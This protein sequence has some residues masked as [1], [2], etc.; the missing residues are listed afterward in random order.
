MALKVTHLQRIVKKV[1][2]TFENMNN[3]AASY[4][5]IISILIDPKV[6]SKVVPRPISV[7]SKESVFD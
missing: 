7:E 3:Y 4:K 6:S 5:P 1:P 2:K